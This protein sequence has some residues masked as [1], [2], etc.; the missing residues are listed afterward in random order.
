MD[1]GSG[2][3][4]KYTILQRKLQDLVAL[5][6]EEQR[7]HQN[8]VERLKQELATT[9][10]ALAERT[11]RFEKQ[12]KSLELCQ[13]KLHDLKTSAM[14][15]Q[16]EIKELRAKLRSLDKD[17]RQ[18]AAEMKKALRS[19][20]V[21]LKEG[22]KERDDKVVGL[23]TK[24]SNELKRRK[25]MEARL[26]ELESEDDRRRAQATEEHQGGEHQGLVLQTI[27][28][29]SDGHSSSREEALVSRLEQY[30]TLLVQ[31]ATEYGRLATAS[32]AASEHARIKSEN[33]TLHLSIH[34]LERK[35]ANA[36]AQV[37][38]LAHLVRHTQE[39]NL[40]LR[41][42]VYDYRAAEQLYSVPAVNAAQNNKDIA[43]Q[44]AERT[45]QFENLGRELVDYTANIQTIS[46]RD[47]IQSN[48]FHR[49]W[50]LSLA[51]A[52]Q[53]LE[54]RL[55]TTQGELIRQRNDR[56]LTSAHQDL[57][58]AKL[59]E[60]EAELATLREGL[61]EATISLKDNHESSRRLQL[62]LSEAEARH[63]GELASAK[64]L[65]A[66]ERTK[67]RHLTTALQNSRTVEDALRAEISQMS[68]ELTEAERFQAA[69]YRLSDEVGE[70][71]ARKALAEDE[72]QR[73]RK[74]NAEIV[75]HNNPA[76]R[77]MYVDR[78]RIE[79]A[80]TKHKLLVSTR[81]LSQ[82]RTHVETLLQE[83]G[84]YKSVMV[85]AD[86]KPRTNLTRIDRPVLVVDL[87]AAGARSSEDEA[88]RILGQHIPALDDDGD[89]M[90][91]EE[92]A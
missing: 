86:C 3:T 74:F 41:D 20:E 6:A 44:E 34:R 71:I 57:L 55:Q 80:D 89:I 72:A 9:R 77:I 22:T 26:Q 21:G 28:P 37:V 24:L 39:E 1:A 30:H 31:V 29:G 75:G 10:K 76:Q 15:D 61:A 13:R 64:E 88:E 79:L 70:V 84:M 5:R 90:T 32:V 65:L 69:F 60:A 48:D 11:C 67:A 92:F 12:S 59:L 42:Q 25:E 35:Y 68:A 4:D 62:S 58:Q 27:V 87:Q 7:E 81:E 85:A 17:K 43:R 19:A 82:L 2:T 40:F 83:L 36:E 56:A 8:E 47:A 23:E 16:A 51:D 49:L 66:Q 91:M 78:I 45:L 38:E 53:V 33:T 50:C 52:C 14:K 73:L 18:D 63:H 54:D 46:H